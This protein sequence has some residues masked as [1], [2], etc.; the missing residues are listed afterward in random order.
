MYH[1]HTGNSLVMSAYNKMLHSATV[2]MKAT[3]IL[4][5]D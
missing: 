2:A 1:F 4:R 3:V 5:N